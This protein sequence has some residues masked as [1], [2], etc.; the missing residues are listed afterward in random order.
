MCGFAICVFGIRAAMVEASASA[1]ILPCSPSV[2]S[3]ELDSD[4][5]DLASDSQSIIDVE[6]AGGQD[7]DLGIGPNGIN[8]DAAFS[9]WSASHVGASLAASGDDVV[10]LGMDAVDPD[11]PC[12][13]TLGGMSPPNAE[14]LARIA[15]LQRPY[16]VMW[17]VPD[18]LAMQPVIRSPGL[19]PMGDGF[20][21]IAGMMRDAVVGNGSHS[22]SID[23]S[24]VDDDSVSSQDP[25]NHCCTWINSLQVDFYIGIT[26]SPERRYEEH[27]ERQTVGYQPLMTVLY[28]ANHSRHTA[29]LERQLLAKYLHWPRCMNLST[30]GEGASAGSPHYLYV[31]HS[32]SSLTRRPPRRSVLEAGPQ[33][34][35]RRRQ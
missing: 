1:V 21:A 27:F 16:R 13:F 30:G 10:G 14:E 35:R 9:H 28:Q 22:G 23:Y 8:V 5:D 11:N 3:T 19:L 20:L 29:S 2:A 24:C 12:G 4:E 33:P 26:E 15:E 32:T 7:S 6:A 18:V 34:I 31:V 25:F 17:S